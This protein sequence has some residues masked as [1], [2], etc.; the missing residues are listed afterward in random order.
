MH[1]YWFQ[2][3]VIIVL[4]FFFKIIYFQFVWGPA[5]VSDAQICQNTISENLKKKY[6]YVSHANS[7]R[8][9]DETLSLSQSATK[10]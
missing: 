4:S 6:V 9:N 5:K 1:R 8:I 10:L 7:V 2:I 3:L